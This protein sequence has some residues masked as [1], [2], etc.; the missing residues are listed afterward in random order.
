MEGK[1]SLAAIPEGTCCEQDRAFPAGLMGSQQT[2]EGKTISSVCM[3]VS[4]TTLARQF[5]PR[6]PGP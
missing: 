3:G 6:E 2:W 4:R 1:R 5:S